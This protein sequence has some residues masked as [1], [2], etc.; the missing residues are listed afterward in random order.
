LIKPDGHN[1]LIYI[2]T[3][4]TAAF[5]PRKRLCRL[6]DLPDGGLTLGALIAHGAAHDWPDPHSR[7]LPGDY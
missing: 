2:K 4:L 3:R 5:G 6:V 7:Q 1:A